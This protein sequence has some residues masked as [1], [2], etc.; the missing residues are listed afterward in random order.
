M[1]GQP[2]GGAG[3]DARQPLELVDQP[4]QGSGVTAQDRSA[5]GLNLGTLARPCPT[6]DVGGAAG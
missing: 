4:R 3:T 1:Q 6:G 5:G 2:L